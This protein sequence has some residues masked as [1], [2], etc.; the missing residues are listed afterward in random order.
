[1]VAVAEAEMEDTGIHRQRRSVLLDAITATLER[2]RSGSERPPPPPPPPSD[3]PT[4]GDLELAETLGLEPD[5][6]SQ[7]ASMH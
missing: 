5:P 1:M 2:F 6:E 4:S 7:R 3:P